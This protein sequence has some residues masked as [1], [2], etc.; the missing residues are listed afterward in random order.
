M[1]EANDL[2]HP[3][4]AHAIDDDAPRTANALFLDNQTPPNAKRV[5]PGARS[6]SDLG[7][8]ARLGYL[9]KS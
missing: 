4:R 5:N 9:L 7:M 6:L 1:R 3:V 2:D 8:A